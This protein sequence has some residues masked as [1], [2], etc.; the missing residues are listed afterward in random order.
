MPLPLCRSSHGKIWRVSSPP[1]SSSL[2]SAWCPEAR[3]IKLYIV[4]RLMADYDFLY[5]P[6]KWHKCETGQLTYSGLSFLSL[7]LTAVFS[8]LSRIGA[9]ISS[10]FSRSSSWMISMSLTGSTLPSTWMIS[11]SSNAP[12]GHEH[13]QMYRSLQF[14]HVEIS[15][16]FIYIAD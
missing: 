1:L 8:S 16:P 3:S 13:W 2:F 9:S 11:S 10:S 12:K 5:P 4:F 14:T 6:Q 15:G 7:P